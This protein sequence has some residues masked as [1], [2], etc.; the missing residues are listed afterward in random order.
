MGKIRFN[1][2][3]QV[4][5]LKE[6]VAKLYLSDF[7]FRLDLRRNISFSFTLTQQEIGG[8]KVEIDFTKYKIRVE[9]LKTQP[10]KIFVE[11]PIIKKRKHMFHDGSLC[12]YHW[13]NFKWDDKKSIA[14]DLI[15]WTYMWVYYYELWLS[16]GIWYSD[17]YKH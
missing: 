9:Y 7:S 10:P 14:R 15:P 2:A 8:E 6:L 13:S 11:H 17:E 3:I 4:A 12:L 1:P 5:A 16:T